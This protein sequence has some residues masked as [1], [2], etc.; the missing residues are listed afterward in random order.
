MT[1]AILC[2]EAVFL[3]GKLF[4]ELLGSSEERGAFSRNA[5]KTWVEGGDVPSVCRAVPLSS[6]VPA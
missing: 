4:C 3:S 1:M 2:L 6:L 5:T